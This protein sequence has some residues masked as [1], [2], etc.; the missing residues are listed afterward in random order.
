MGRMWDSVCG[1]TVSGIDLGKS[2]K[3]LNTS[4]KNV[5]RQPQEKGGC[6]EPKESTR[7]LGGEILPG[8][9]GRDLK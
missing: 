8:L 4:R 1:G 9:K 6:W 2:I 3:T 7:D 5:N